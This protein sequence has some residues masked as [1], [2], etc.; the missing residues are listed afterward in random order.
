M[1]SHRAIFVFDK[2]HTR[3]EHKDPSEPRPILLQV[4]IFIHLCYYTGMY[5]IKVYD[6]KRLRILV[7][8]TIY[9]T[10]RIGRDGH[11]DQSEA[12]DIS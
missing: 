7:H 2:L 10:L 11:H 12:W 4:A 1:L 6:K 3:N 8:I 9:R 5:I